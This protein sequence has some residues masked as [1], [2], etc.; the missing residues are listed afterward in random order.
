MMHGIFISSTR[1]KCPPT[2]GNQMTPKELAAE[3]NTDARTCRK[4]LRSLTDDRAGKGGRWIIDADDL[5]SLRDR[6]DAYNARRT[7]TLIITTDD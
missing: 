7:T 1:G 5:D 4:F 6:F 2:K 3:L